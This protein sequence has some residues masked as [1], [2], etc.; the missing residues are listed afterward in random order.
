MAQHQVALERNAPDLLKAIKD[1]SMKTDGISNLDW[2]EFMTVIDELYP[3]FSKSL[4]DKLGII[5]TKQTY[6]CY[7]LKAGFRNTEIEYIIKDVSR[8]TIWRWIKIYRETLMD[9]INE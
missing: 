4:L 6:V 7:L 1:S 5:K 3:N 9:D 8:S 2:K